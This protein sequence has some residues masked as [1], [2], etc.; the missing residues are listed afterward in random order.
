[1][2]RYWHY[3]KNVSGTFSAFYFES[4]MILVMAGRFITDVDNAVMRTADEH[5]NN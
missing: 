5:F 4:V 1:M 3:F 2:K